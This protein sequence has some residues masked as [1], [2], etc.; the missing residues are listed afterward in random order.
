MRE[1]G[2][3]L[4]RGDEVHSYMHCWRHKTPV[5]CAP[6][7][8]GSPAWTTCRAT[9]V[10]R[11]PEHAARHGFAR[12]RGDA[13]LSVV[14]QGRDSRHDRESSRL[15]A[16]APAQWGVPMP[17]FVHK[18]TGELHPRALELLEAVAKRVEKAASKRGS[19]RRRG[20]ARAPMRRTTRKS[21][22]RS[23]SGSIPA[24]RTTPCCA[25]SHAAESCFPGRS[26]SRRLRPAPRLVPFVAADG[27]HDGRGAAVRALLTHGFVVD[28]SGRKMSK[29]KGNVIAPQEVM[30]SS[31]RT[32]CGCGSRRPTTRASSRSRKRF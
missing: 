15:D 17:F 20:A 31:A 5:I 18:E 29:S 3:L 30:D 12:R 16:F 22:T 32:S 19:A 4:A 27:V 8:S 1:R 9:R 24:R 7:R 10:S 6:R 11:P 13:V 26:V 14:G 25:G 28:G 21:K 2:V 23:T